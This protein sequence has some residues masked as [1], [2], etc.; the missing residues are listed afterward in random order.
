MLCICQNLKTPQTSTL[1]WIP[2][3][4]NSTTTVEK[5][6]NDIF[7]LD[8][9]EWDVTFLFQ[10]CMQISS[11]TFSQHFLGAQVHDEGSRF[12]V[13]H[14]WRVIVVRV[15]RFTFRRSSAS[16][17]WATYDAIISCSKRNLFLLVSHNTPSTAHS[18]RDYKHN[19]QNNANVSPVIFISFFFLDD[20]L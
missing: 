13:P 3:Y 15:Y 10:I 19:W 20:H 5:A 2:A 11:R 7:S 4:R 1:A 8:C 16:G 17:M 14:K 12:F 9:A 6:I 18:A